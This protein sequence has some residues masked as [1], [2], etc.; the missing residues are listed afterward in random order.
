MKRRENEHGFS[1]V[2]VLVVIGIIGILSGTGAHALG[3]SRERAALS[4]SAEELLAAVRETQTRAL[5]AHGG[6]GW[7]FTCSGSEWQ[8]FAYNPA[9]GNEVS[10]QSFPL[11]QPLTCS[12]SQPGGIR[13]RKLTGIPDADGSFTL[14]HPAAG[15]KRLD[16]RIPGTMTL[17]VI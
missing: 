12:A 9:N 15:A 3:R 10:R 4:A 13:F 5:T 17:S 2:E 7:G 6:L 11:P 1:L 16:V 8:R 14:T